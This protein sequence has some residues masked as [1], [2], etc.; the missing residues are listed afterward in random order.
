[1]TEKTAYNGLVYRSQHG[2]GTWHW[3]SANGAPISDDT[4]NVTAI[5]VTIRDITSDKHAEQTMQ[6]TLKRLE[7]ALSQNTMLMREVHHRVKNNMAVIA[8]LLALQS[9]GLKD[10]TPKKPCV[11]AAPE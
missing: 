9:H 5:L 10:A 7:Q 6:A 4:G 1:M 3:F 8:S 11:K 2:D